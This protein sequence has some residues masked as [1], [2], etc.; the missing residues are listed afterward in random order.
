[1]N[2]SALLLNEDDE[3]IRKA[4]ALSLIT[5]REDELR[6]RQLYRSVEAIPQ[7]VANEM[8]WQGLHASNS[9]PNLTDDSAKSSTANAI[10]R[11]RPQGKLVN[12]GALNL[13]VAKPLP[14]CPRSPRHTRAV[15]VVPP[16]PNV[17]AV[18]PPKQRSS[19]T[20][21]D[22][23]GGNRGMTGHVASGVPPRPIVG[24]HGRSSAKIPPPRPHAIHP[25]GATPPKADIDTPLITL[26][27]RIL[28]NPDDFDVSSLDPLSSA[29]SYSSG[30]TTTH[31]SFGEDLHVSLN[32]PGHSTVPTT[33]NSKIAAHVFESSSSFGMAAALPYP[34]CDSTGSVATGPSY[35]PR[36]STG[37]GAASPSFPSSIGTGLHPTGPSY[38]HRSSA[39]S[40]TTYQLF[41]CIAADNDLSKLL[42]IDNDLYNMSHKASTGKP[43]ADAPSSDVAISLSEHNNVQPEESVRSYDI[44]G[45]CDNADDNLMQFAAGYD[46]HKLLSLECFDPLY[47]VEQPACSEGAAT[48][49]DSLELF[50]N[51][52]DKFERKETPNPFPVVDPASTQRLLLQSSVS[53]T[54][55]QSKDVTSDVDVTGNKGH[56]RNE[57]SGS[58]SELMDPFSIAN[59]T[60]ALERKRKKHEKEQKERKTL[61]RKK[62]AKMKE[63]KASRPVP[64]RPTY[65]RQSSY[66]S[67]GQVMLGSFHIKSTVCLAFLQ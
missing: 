49:P 9:Y 57:S 62:E 5:A 7:H 3:A 66:L 23:L 14:P 61:L 59:L 43:Q 48:T 24:P 27:P 45:A 53:V 17:A 52:Y 25:S 56:T 50:P 4:K 40:S 47:S 38:P 20:N 15:P 16:R 36:G 41:D 51:P 35:P 19:S 29:R 8:A 30:A 2:S 58:N 42:F 65:S 31:A 26:S 18:S 11:P 12:K 37:S 1:M 6:R 54:S 13:P 64:S 63:E 21:Q 10:A 39:G 67:K 32:R 46:H 33:H 60:A 55:Q 28:P 44:F 22:D 34:L